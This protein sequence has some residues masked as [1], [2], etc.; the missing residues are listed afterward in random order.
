MGF[1]P[2]LPAWNV[3]LESLRPLWFVSYY[4]FVSGYPKDS[5]MPRRLLVEGVGVCLGWNGK[6]H[7]FSCIY[8]LIFP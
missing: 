3:S 2:R 5:L 6:W 1:V 7:K 4:V 8:N